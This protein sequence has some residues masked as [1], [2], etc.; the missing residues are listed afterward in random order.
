MK[1]PWHRSASV[2]SSA[3]HMLYSLTP[4]GSSTVFQVL[5]CQRKSTF[6]GNLIC[7]RRAAD[8]H[9]NSCQTLWLLW[10]TYN[11]T[12]RGHGAQGK[13]AKLLRIL[14]EQA[15]QKLSTWGAEALWG[16]WEG[17]RVARNSL[18]LNKNVRVFVE[19]LGGETFIRFSGVMAKKWL[20]IIESVYY[21]HRY[22]FHSQMSFFI[23]QEILEYINIIRDLKIIDGFEVSFILPCQVCSS[24]FC[25][26]QK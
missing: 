22:V 20:R 8:A 17:F 14:K 7:Q 19:F 21:F 5:R 15:G 16:L 11:G 18:K 24:Y 13:K 1:L 25:S 6:W 12:W 26:L 9:K 4:Q 3:D 23:T 2:C 10:D